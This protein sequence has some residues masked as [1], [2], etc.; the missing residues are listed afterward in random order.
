[1]RR[2][3]N[4]LE[5]KNRELARK[6]RL[7]DLG[8]MASHVA[9][10]VRNGLAPVKL[11]LS[12]LRRCLVERDPE[13]KILDKAERGMGA[14]ETTVTD[15]LHFTIDRDPNRCTFPAR[16]LFSEI[17]DALNPQLVAQ[18]IDVSIVAD[19]RLRLHADIDMLRRAIFNLVLNA[20]D[21][22]PSGGTLRLAASAHAGS[23]KLQVADSGPGIPTDVLSRVFEPFF[24]TKSHGTGLGLSIVYRIVEMHGGEV[25]VVN[26]PD[27]G[28]EFTI[29]IPA[30]PEEI[31]T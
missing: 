14:L 21:A 7:A 22:L 9:H 27:G 10:E 6:N 26:G 2:L 24:T 29:C 5:T 18:Q 1:M 28:A 19:D 20:L 3:T 13:L 15:L 4:E 25:Q 30:T 23:T 16:Q 31:P 8:Q 17:V 11:Y 12:L